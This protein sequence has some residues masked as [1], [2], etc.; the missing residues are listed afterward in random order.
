[1]G[2]FKEQCVKGE[3]RFPKFSATGII[4]DKFYQ[5]HAES[6]DA[7]MTRIL[8][9]QDP[10][11][12][13]GVGI[14][15]ELPNAL[16]HAGLGKDTD[17]STSQ[18]SLATNLL[19]A[20]EAQF[21]NPSGTLDNI[22]KEGPPPGPLVPKSVKKRASQSQSLRVQAHTNASKKTRAS[23][24]MSNP[25]ALSSLPQG[26]P[27]GQTIYLMGQG[28]AADVAEQMTNFAQPTSSTSLQGL[29]QDQNPDMMDQASANNTGYF[30]EQTSE[31]IQFN[32][33]NMSHAPPQGQDFGL[34]GQAD[35]NHT[36]YVT[37]QVNN[38]ELSAFSSD[39][40]GHFLPP[41]LHPSVPG[42]MDG[43]DYS[44]DDLINHTFQ[45]MLDGGIFPNTAILTTQAASALGRLPEQQ[46]GAS[47]PGFDL[48][49]QQ[50]TNMP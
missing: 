18:P 27:Q 16:S 44:G 11:K 46:L 21:G 23:R 2:D 33:S 30:T 50:P 42:Q 13:E 25:S 34:M 40:Q 37:G 7:Q 41:P 45:A 39:P 43:I 9:E 1:M 6:A 38:F 48:R 36:R 29:S 35:A 19:A 49:E 10:S 24:Q 17:D 47:N 3:A 12:V 20:D 31:F 15:S 5:L 28:N 32:A 4:R 26:L 22:N 8:E 14:L